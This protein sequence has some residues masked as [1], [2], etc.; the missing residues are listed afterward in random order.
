MLFFILCV[1]FYPKSY[2]EKDGDS[3]WCKTVII[4]KMCLG[5]SVY[6]KEVDDPCTESSLCFGLLLPIKK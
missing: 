6:M 4:E 1:F 5:K 3:R 2:Y